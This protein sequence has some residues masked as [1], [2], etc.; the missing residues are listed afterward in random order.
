MSIDK[1]L[2]N[3]DCGASFMTFESQYNFSYISATKAPIFM[4][5]ETEVQ[6]KVFKDG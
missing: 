2:L 4:K 5:F 3:A 1:V 6:R